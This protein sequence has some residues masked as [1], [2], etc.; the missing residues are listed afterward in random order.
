MR[1]LIRFVFALVLTAM[2]VTSCGDRRGD[3]FVACMDSLYQ[4]NPQAAID[5][6]DSFM[7]H[8]SPSRRN[9]MTL[10]LYRLRAQNSAD[11]PFKSD[12]VARLVVEY[13]DEHGTVQQQM[14]AYYVLGSVYRD[15]GNSPEALAQY[16][17]AVELA[18][19]TSTDTDYNC[20]SVYM[21]KLAMCFILSLPSMKRVRRMA[22]RRSTLIG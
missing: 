22:W 16:Q 4:Q 19:T 17:H 9:R 10:S 2:S 20:C 14:S 1:F 11:I 13:F 6:I 3:R 18:D 7:A 5:S 12:S 8:E 15:L 21:G